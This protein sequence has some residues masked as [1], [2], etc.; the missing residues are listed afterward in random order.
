MKKMRKTVAKE[1]KK[2]TLG[3]NPEFNVEHFNNRLAS[4]VMGQL[5]QQVMYQTNAVRKDY[6]ELKALW[7]ATPKT[8]R[9]LRA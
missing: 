6:R 2:I 9:T 4:I 5:P 1:L 7:K 8:Q 3:Q